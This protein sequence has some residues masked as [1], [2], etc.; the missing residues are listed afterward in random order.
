M[1][2]QVGVDQVVE[3]CLVFDAFLA[4]VGDEPLA[5]TQVFIQS[6]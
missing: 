3:V 2:G 6:A 4:C 5:F 1:I